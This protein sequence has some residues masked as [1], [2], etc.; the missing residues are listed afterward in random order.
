MEIQIKKIRKI[1]S[2]ILVFCLFYLAQNFTIGQL[3]IDFNTIK[4]SFIYLK[5]IIFFIT[6]YFSTKNIFD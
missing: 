3:N 6:S 2:L 4:F 5:E 1:N